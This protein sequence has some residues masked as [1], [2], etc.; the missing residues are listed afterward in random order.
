MMCL[1]LIIGPDA[2]SS[3]PGP[4]VPV[5]AVGAE[6]VSPPL[7]QQPAVQAPLAAVAREARHV[8]RASSCSDSLSLINLLVALLAEVQGCVNVHNWII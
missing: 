3:S 7:A 5:V 4:E 8:P 2:V 1:C 6:H